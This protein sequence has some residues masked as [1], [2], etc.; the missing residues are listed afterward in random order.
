MVEN[1][2]TLRQLS[3][4]SI[5]VDVLVKPNHTGGAAAKSWLALAAGHVPICARSITGTM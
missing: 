1:V 5:N 4:N 2:D 3:R